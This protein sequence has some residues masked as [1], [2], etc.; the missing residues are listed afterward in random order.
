MANSVPWGEPVSNCGFQSGCW[1]D[2]RFET[3]INGACK[4]SVFLCAWINLFY[5]SF[6]HSAPTALSHS[7]LVSSPP[8]GSVPSNWLWFRYS[9]VNSHWQACYKWEKEKPS[10][11][12]LRRKKRGTISFFPQ[13]SITLCWWKPVTSPIRL[14][15]ALRCGVIGTQNKWLSEFIQLLRQWFSTFLLPCPFST[16]PYIVV[17]PNC[18]CVFFDALYGK[19][20]AWYVTLGGFGPTQ[21]EEPLL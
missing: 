18:Q 14:R 2:L 20:N 21:V 7:S 5:H 10:L 3:G 8:P 11:K 1:L 15:A 6:S 12:L 16:V 19:H 9:I 4:E 17:T 13:D